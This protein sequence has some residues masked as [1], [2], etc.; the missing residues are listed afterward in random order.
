M[1]G[2]TKISGKSHDNAD[3]KKKLSKKILQKDTIATKLSLKKLST[4]WQK[5]WEK[6]TKRRE[7]SQ[8]LTHENLTKILGIRK[9]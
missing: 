4:N 3:L 1:T 7:R 5:S 2:L 6:V 9:L 8:K